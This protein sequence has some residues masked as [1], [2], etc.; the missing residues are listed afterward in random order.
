MSST[1]TK[2]E[3]APSDAITAADIATA[4]RIAGRGYGEAQREL[5]VGSLTRTRDRLKIVRKA[6]L[7]GT[8]PAVSFDPR[9]PDTRIPRGPSRSRVSRGR[10][11]RYSGDPESLAF[12]TVVELSRLIKARKV[13]STGLTQMYLDRLKR[14]DPLLKCVVTLTEDLALERAARADQ[15]IAAGHYRGPLHGIPW[16][17]KD[18]LATKGI[19]TTWGARPYEHQVFDSDATVVRRLEEAGAVLIAKLSMGELAVNDVWFG[20]KT[21]NPWHP[22]QGS[23]GSS[24]GSGSAT[25]AGLVGFS[26]GSETIGSIVSPCTVCGVTGLRPTYGRVSRHGAMALC[27]TL[28]KLG[29]MCRGVEDCALVFSAIHG[30]D[31]QDTTV[32]DVPF[33]WDPRSHLH[34]IRVGLDTAALATLEKEPARKAV[35]DAALDTLRGLGVELHP[36]ALPQSSPAYESLWLILSV[37]SGA[38]FQKLTL[39]GGVDLLEGQDEGNWPNTFRVGSTVPAVDYLQ[40]M[41]LRRQLQH[42]MA[43]AMREVDVCVTVP[44]TGPN[45][46][47]TNC[48]GHP[49]VVTRCGM[50]DGKPQSLEFLGALYHEAAALHVAYAYEQA[51]GWH[52]QWPDLGT[53]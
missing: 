22:E 43:E 7:D 19:R 44:L 50:L 11:P 6:D 25:A 48:T 15:E 28:D 1:E 12:L 42:A 47:F 49:T 24:A 38:S 26:I 36:V 35:Y 32:A 27:W 14:F 20:G 8:E 18:L 39:S 40:V 31:G 41:R 10:R 37:E 9:L 4:D 16:G 51:T 29:P 3:A 13:S 33:R 17:V 52:K 23:S 53:R 45:T 21:R 30:P 34:E 2:P 46:L 5:M